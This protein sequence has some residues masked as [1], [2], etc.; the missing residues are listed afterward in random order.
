VY[1]GRWSAS[2]RDF[3]REI[4]PMAC[5]LGLAL[6]PWGALGGG[7]YK[8]EEQIAERKDRNEQGRIV[9]RRPDVEEADR[10]I[11]RVLHKIAKSRGPDIGVTGIALAYV[12]HKAP[13]VF[14]IVGGRKI[15]HLKENIAA[16]TVRLTDEEIKEIEA[17]GNDFR[18]GFPHEFLGSG[19]RAAVHAG[20]VGFVKLSGHVDFHEPRKV[21]FRFVEYAY[22]SQFFRPRTARAQNVL[23]SNSFSNPRRLVIGEYYRR[24]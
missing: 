22:N 3:E 11:T 4:I 7:R 18:M 9:S 14:P 24:Y 8:T 17:A 21:C 12:M 16:L 6:A 5:N 23:I 19:G 2:D 1:Q 13:D 20:Q 15:Q 10:R